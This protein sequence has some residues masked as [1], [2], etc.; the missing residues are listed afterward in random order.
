LINQG[1]LIHMFRRLGAAGSVISAVTLLLLTAGTV[2]AHNA[3]ATMTC[4]EERTEVHVTAS[5]YPAGST[6][7]VAIDGGAALGPF[8][9]NT[10]DTDVFDAGSPTVAHTAVVT[11]HSADGKTQFDFVFQL[12]AEAC[13]EQTP[14]PTPSASATP[15]PTPEQSVAG[16][17][18]PSPE[19]SVQGGTGTPEPSQPDTAM[20]AEGGPSPIPTLAFGTILVAALGALAWVNIKT[21]RSRA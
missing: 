14:T 17:S 16:T 13:V 10:G 6:Y 3:S 9:A 1:E 5:S 19:Q 18:T 8:D 11:F 21:A 7:T 12:S 4:G 2:A 20:G 15:S